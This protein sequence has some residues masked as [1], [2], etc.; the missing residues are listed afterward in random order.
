MRDSLEASSVVKV[1]GERRGSAED[2]DHELHLDSSRG[3]LE[4]AFGYRTCRRDTEL[5]TRRDQP[6]VALLSP[7]WNEPCD[8][9]KEKSPTARASDA[10]VKPCRCTI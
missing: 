7:P 5:T 9:H 8:F 10:I 2:E 4:V 6:R 3:G 1:Q